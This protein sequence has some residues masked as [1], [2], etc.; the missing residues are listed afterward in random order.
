M[1]AIYSPFLSNKFFLSNIFNIFAFL[2]G[3]KSGTKIY[4]L[5]ETVRDAWHATQV[6]GESNGNTKQHS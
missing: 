4:H 5:G 6:V 2:N 3:A 1:V